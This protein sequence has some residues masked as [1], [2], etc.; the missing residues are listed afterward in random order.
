M[1]EPIAKGDGWEIV[2]RYDG[3]VVVRLLPTEGHH[4]GPVSVVYA[5]HFPRIAKA[6]LEAAEAL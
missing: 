3:Q 1:T 5:H 4:G 2:K 6:A